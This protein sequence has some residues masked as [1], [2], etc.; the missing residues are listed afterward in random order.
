MSELLTIDI[1]EEI[2][3]GILFDIGQKVT[4]VKNY[5]S[6]CEY[7]LETALGD[8]LESLDYQGCECRISIGA[9]NFIYRNIRL[10]F[11]DKQKIDQIL[12]FEVEEVFGVSQDDF[13]IDFLF[14]KNN[15]EAGADVLV[16]MIKKDT[17]KSMLSVFDR[18]GIGPTILTVSGSMVPGCLPQAQQSVTNTFFFF[19]LG[20]K[21]TTFYLFEDGQPTVIRHLNTEIVKASEEEQN[22]LKNCPSKITMSNIEGFVTKLG[23]TIN[24]TMLAE[25]KQHLFDESVPCFVG[26]SY[27]GQNEFVEVFNNILSEDVMSS[28]VSNLPFLKIEHQQHASWEPQLMQNALALGLYKKQKKNTFNFRKGLF[29]KS[30]SLKQYRKSIILVTSV[31]SVL[32]LSGSSFGWWEI[33][34]LKKEQLRLREQIELVFKETVPGVTRIVNPIHQLQVRVDEINDHYKVNGSGNN[35]LSKIELLTILSQKIDPKYSVIINR[36]VMGNLDV[37]MNGNADTFNTVDNI[38]KVLAESG[39]FRGVEISS[40]NHD[41]KSE[42]VRFD[43]KLEL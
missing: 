18:F 10:P 27:G 28:D 36:L 14:K 15:V 29:K 31:L 13:Q 24:Q 11:T 33:Q 8:I 3:T 16:A 25:Q 39:Y 2:V 34:K 4:V 5:A 7:E 42:M 6:H 12:S 23:K 43:L 38:K 1:Q 26:G 22:N 32:C 40:A 41:P 20:C 35:Q 19:D 17:L 9:E 21:G 37:R 30:I